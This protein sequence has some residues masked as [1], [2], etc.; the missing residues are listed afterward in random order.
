MKAVRTV[1]SHLTIRTRYLAIQK[2]CD[3]KEGWKIEDEDGGWR[4][5]FEEWRMK[6]G[7]ER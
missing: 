4:M 7:D 5:K 6:D 1:E 2:Q 3:R